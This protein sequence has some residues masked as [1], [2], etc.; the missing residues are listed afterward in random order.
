MTSLTLSNATPYIAMFT[1]L[2]GEQ[3]VA[4]IPGIAPGAQLQIPE[5]HTYQVTASTILDGNIYTS[6]PIDVDGPSSFLARMLRLPSQTAYEFNV[7]E[8]PST[9]PDQLQF[10]KTTLSPVTFFISR[11]GI[12]L[13]HVVVTDVSRMK[14]LDIS[15]H[16]QVHAVINGITTQTVTTTDPDAVITAVVDACSLESG[17]FTLVVG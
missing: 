12:M 15:G 3:V 11:E 13:Q 6:A 9:R 16:Y 17:C 7:V 10:H 5:T 1:V 2:K 8:S 14:T 4:R